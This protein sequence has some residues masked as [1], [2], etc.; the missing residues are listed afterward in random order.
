MSGNAMLGR[1]RLKRG[2]FELD[3]I[4]WTPRLTKPNIKE[5]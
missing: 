4:S 2:D 1:Q 3:S 5:A